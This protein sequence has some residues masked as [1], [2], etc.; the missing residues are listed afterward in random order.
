MLYAFRPW[1][2]HFGEPQ[3]AVMEMKED[4]MIKGAPVKHVK[5]DQIVA[6]GGLTYSLCDADVGLLRAKVPN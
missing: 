2:S 3:L 1:G 5:V 6:I 4:R